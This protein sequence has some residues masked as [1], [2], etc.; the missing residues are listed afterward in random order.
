MTLAKNAAE[1]AAAVH[2]RMCDHACRSQIAK[3]TAQTLIPDGGW[4]RDSLGVT[5]GNRLA[6]H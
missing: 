4:S 2:G 3:Q 5:K 6:P 1:R